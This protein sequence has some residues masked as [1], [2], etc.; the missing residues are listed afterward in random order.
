MLEAILIWIG[1][2]IVNTLVL[3]VFMCVIFLLGVIGFFLNRKEQKRKA[4]VSDY[5]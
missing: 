2:N 1:W 4:N 5:L 3:L